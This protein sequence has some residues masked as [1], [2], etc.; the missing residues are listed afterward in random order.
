MQT[1]KVKAKEKITPQ[2]KETTIN[3]ETNT[4]E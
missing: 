2:I 3:T 4:E 1:I